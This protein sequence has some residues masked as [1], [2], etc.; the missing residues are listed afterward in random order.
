MSE[1]LQFDEATHTYRVAGRV[2]PNVTQV[3]EGVFRFYSGIPGDVL[4]A[5][6][7]R[8]VAVHHHTVAWDAGQLDID[9]IPPE[10][11]DYVLAWARWRADT[12]AEILESE[13]RGFH[14]Q[15]RY[16]GTLDR[17]VRIKKR[18]VLLDIKTTWKML[19]GTA[20]QTAA[21]ERLPGNGKIDARLTVRLDRSGDYEVK[22]WVD[23]ND[24]AVFLGALTCF[25]WRKNN[26][27]D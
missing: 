12:G 4:A 15:Y 2:V 20:I 7:H 24:F 19:P 14:P 23:P 1:A 17:I 10:H 16:A 13:R 8:G 22:T 11:V 18:R 5:A 21:Y 9:T 6:A 25:N 27:I 26:V 3:I